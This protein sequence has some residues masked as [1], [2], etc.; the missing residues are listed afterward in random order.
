ML[1]IFVLIKQVPKTSNLEIDNRTGSL[2]REGVENIINPDDVYALELGL[3][4]KEQYGGTVTAVTMG[5]SQANIALRECLAMGL[6]RAIIDCDPVFAYSDTL[7]TTLVLK[8]TFEKIKD[9]DIIITGS[10]TADSSTGQVPFQLSEAL[11]IPLITDIFTYSIE[12]RVFKCY[13]NFG[14]EAQNIEVDLP[15][16]I[17]VR[18]HFNEPRSIPLLGIKKAFDREI[19]ITDF[20]AL[21]CPEN[22]DGRNKSPTK[23]VKTE[24]IVFKRK[25]QLIEGTIKE[26]IKVLTN[27]M[28]EH[29]IE[30]IWT[31][32]KN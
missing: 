15:I 9:Y 23:V 16:I 31:G 30:K 29:G 1:N 32:K 21:N 22:L 12:N 7:Q 19:G 11:Q 20:N 10:E 3:N 2:I 5:P 27:I 4:L 24:K 6:D 8:E 13:R 17:R 26:K 25:N 18:R 28:R 14:H